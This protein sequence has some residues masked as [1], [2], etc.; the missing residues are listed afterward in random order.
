[1]TCRRIDLGGGSAVWSCHRPPV[2]PSCSVCGGAGSGLACQ[3]ELAGAKAG[4]RCGKALCRTCA[5]TSSP[6]LCPPHRR[7]VAARALTGGS[8]P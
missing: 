5:G 7:L 8:H 3:F 6:A 1:M 2:R 4:E